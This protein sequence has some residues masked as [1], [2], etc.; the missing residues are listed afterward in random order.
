MPASETTALVMP[1]ESPFERRKKLIALTCILTV[2]TLHSVA[3]WAMYLQLYIFLDTL[4]TKMET[5]KIPDS[6]TVILI[7]EAVSYLVMPAIGGILGD[8]TLGRYQAIFIGTFFELIGTTCFLVVAAIQKGSTISP[9]AS[10]GVTIVS[11][12]FIAIGM[13]FIKANVVPFGAQQVDTGDFS[14]VQGFMKWYTWCLNLGQLIAYLPMVY[15]ITPSKNEEDYGFLIAAVI[16]VFAVALAIAV[17]IFGKVKYKMKHPEGKTT[18]LQL[19][20][21]IKE[22][23]CCAVNYV[24]PRNLGI[25]RDSKVATLILRQ[26]ILLAMLFSMLITYEGIYFQMQNTYIDQSKKLQASSE[27]KPGLMY[28]FNPLAVLIGIPLLSCLNFYDSANPRYFIRLSIGVTF[29]VFSA[30]MAGLVQ[31]SINPGPE[32]NQTDKKTS[33]WAQVPQFAFIGIGE[34]F[35]EVA[36]YEIAYAESPPGIEGIVTAMFSSSFGAGSLIGSVLYYNFSKP[37][38]IEWLYFIFTIVTAI[39]IPLIIIYSRFYKLGKYRKYRMSTLQGGTNSGLMHSQSQT[40]FN[41]T[42]DVDEFSP[43]DT[44][45]HIDQDFFSDSEIDTCAPTR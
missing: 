31:Y 35:T 34:V 32:G 23:F 21:G 15:I 7:F 24:T 26:V 19:A 33:I 25:N 14:Q 9:E 45:N 42:D 12:V 5:D 13:G 39:M 2:H 44:S 29:G 1:K 18:L 4:H 28:I 36:G 17:F 3:F 40:S 8:V 37:Y 38:D 27:I 41:N 20:A 43:L 22:R 30:L 11:L 10:F 16:Q 6:S